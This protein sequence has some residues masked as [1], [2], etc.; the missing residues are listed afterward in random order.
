MTR[1][2]CIEAEEK[3]KGYFNTVK[4][5]NIKETYLMR[6]QERLEKA[7]NDLERADKSFTLSSDMQGVVYDRVLVDGGSLPQSSM[8]RELERI[9][10]RLEEEV[11]KISTEIVLTNI[12]IRQLEKSND[13]VEGFLNE[14]DDLEKE[15][16]MLRFG[17]QMSFEAIAKEIHMAKSNVDRKFRKML[18]IFFEIWMQ[19]KS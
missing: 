17:H 9:F 16:F 2:E 3:L 11:S 6:L 18:K 15:I 19:E 4:L 8:D 10:F 7:K 12:V 14:L 5:I 1:F 13:A